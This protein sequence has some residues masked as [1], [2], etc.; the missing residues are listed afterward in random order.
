VKHSRANRK[1]PVRLLRTT[2]SQPFWLIAASGAANWP[3][4]L[5]TSP[6]MRPVCSSVPATIARTCSSSRMSRDRMRRASRLRDLG[7]H[8]LQ[9]VRLAPDE[10]H[11]RTEAR[12][13]VR[14]AATDPAA[15]SGDDVRLAC[16][17]PGPEDRVEWHARS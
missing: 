3:P 10:H 16:E 14:R 15:A 11:R 17:Q 13:L 5:L 9:P 1:P 6:S 4:A 8:R 12:Q 7:A 2:A